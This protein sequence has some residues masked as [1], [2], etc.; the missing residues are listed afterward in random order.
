M[1]KNYSIFGL[2]HPALLL[3]YALMAPI[4]VMLTGHP[5]YVAIN[6]CM[7]L[8]VHCFYFGMA[9][10]RRRGGLMSVCIL[11]VAL[12]NFCFNTRGMH[13][14]FRIGRHP[15]TLESLLYGL[16]SGG[17]LAAVIL[18]FQCFNKIVS[19]EKFLYLFG[20]R[21]PGTALLVSMILKLF[22]D[23]R[24]RMHCIRYADKEVVGSRK[25][26]LMHR[27]RKGLR[28]LS[29]LMEWSMEDSIEKAD[30]MKARGYGEGRRS[31]WQLYIWSLGDT[32]LGIWM[33]IFVSVSLTGIIFYNAGLRWYPV[34]QTGESSVLLAV[35][36]ICYAGFLALPLWT[37]WKVRWNKRW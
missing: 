10:T 26:S 35:S 31:S 6:L 18:W 28:Q 32:V 25:A 14:L 13:V 24:Y 22:P 15:L 33:T 37:E 30:S 4:S 34:I 19:N 8:V 9:E 23:T 12:M 7:A 3:V 29:V 20:K 5:F 16:T 2:Y 11:V 17:E 1:K 21:L 27:A 36:G